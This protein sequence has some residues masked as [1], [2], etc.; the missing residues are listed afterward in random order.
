MNRRRPAPPLPAKEEWD[1]RQV[2]VEAVADCVLWEYS[3]QS[4]VVRPAI[5]EW[6]ESKVSGETVVQHLCD[7]AVT[8]SCFIGGATPAH[9]EVYEEGLRVTKDFRLLQLIEYRK[10]FP[11]PWLRK[12]PK[13]AVDH[14]GNLV[15]PRR[16]TVIEGRR[17]LMNGDLVLQVDWTEATAEEIISEFRCWVRTEAKKHADEMRQRGKPGQLPFDPLKWLAALRLKNA[18]FTYEA[19]Y[20]ALEGCSDGGNVIPIYSEPGGWS[21][22]IRNANCRLRTMETR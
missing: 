20:T 7:G 22:A 5:K 1:F 9:R 18:G 14:N 16:V 2:P 8:R 4:D 17:K 19:A 15:R 21:R 6:M 12:P 13:Y 3:R 11:A 10:D